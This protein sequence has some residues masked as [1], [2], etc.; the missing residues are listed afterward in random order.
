ML[1]VLLLI[2]SSL[3]RL[4]VCQLQS[5]YN[6]DQTLA[7]DDF[8][9]DPASPISA[10]C[11]A[12]FTCDT[13]LYCLTQ[14][15]EQWIGSCTDQSFQNRACP[16]QLNITDP[17]NFHSRFFSFADNVTECPDSGSDKIVCPSPNNTAC[18]TNH[19]GY[20]VTTF[21][22]TAIIPL[23]TAGLPTYYASGGFSVSGLAVSSTAPTSIS[24]YSA[25]PTSSALVAQS[26]S[27]ATGLSKG[28]SAGIGVGVALGALAI[29]AIVF[30]VIWLRKK[31]RA[32]NMQQR[33][34]NLGSSK[35]TNADMMMSR[36]P[37]HEVQ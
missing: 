1:S 26:T 11:P 30:Y 8:P 32:L 2:L 23:S 6:I 10:C 24:S 5:C 22:N 19:N 15:N 29:G 4:C 27:K 31:N 20:T 28:A 25:P 34:Y 17:A 33:G 3:I 21:A 18:C 16:L 14:T 37:I 36:D 13:N 35:M 7:P 12:N 9:C